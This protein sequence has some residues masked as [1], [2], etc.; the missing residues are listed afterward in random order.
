M[1]RAATFPE[2][3][4]APE[5]PALLAEYAAE[6]RT[7]GMPPP[8]GKMESY[9]Q[10]DA[11]GVLHIFGAWSDKT[12]VGFVFVLAAPLLHYSVTT[13]VTESF[14]VGKAHRHT[15][16]GMKLLKAAEDKARELGSPGLIVSAP[17]AG[18][19]FE[20]LPRCG[21]TEVSRIFFKKVTND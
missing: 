3:E 7:E 9:R 20:V 17:F 1:I 5:W 13:A 15:G 11:A 14:F 6:S 8:K 12:L 21:Y 19:L 2:I 10:Y 4:V 18:R 16:A